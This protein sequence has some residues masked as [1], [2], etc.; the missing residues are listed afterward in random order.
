MNEY[1]LKLQEDRKFSF[2]IVGLVAVLACLVALVAVNKYGAGEASVSASAENAVSGP[3][4]GDQGQQ[5]AAETPSGIEEPSGPEV[6]QETEAAE[7]PVTPRGEAVSF[8]IATTTTSTTA[9]PTTVAPSTAAPDPA[10]AP[11]PGEG[12]EGFVDTGNGVLVPPVLL[13]I[14]FC[15]STDNYQAKNPRSTAAGG[16]QFLTGSWKGYGHADRY[17][18]S[19]A[20]QATPAQQDEAALLTWQADGTRPW[21]ASESCWSKR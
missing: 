1:L 21:K 18:V 17:G 10:P 12:E 6:Q 9:P 19:T 4:E 2:A 5:D 8:G 15:E 3:D 20:D 7:E 14:R 13:K 16:Y 11:E